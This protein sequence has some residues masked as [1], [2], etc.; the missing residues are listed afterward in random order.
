MSSPDPGRELTYAQALYE[1]THQEM[2]R[3]PDVFV[4]GMGVDDPKGIHGTTKDLHERFGP[5]RC[6]DT[7]LAEDGMTGIAIGAAMAGMRPVHVHE[8]VDFM[9]LCMNQ[10]I[11]FAAKARYMFAGRV[12]VPLTVRAAIGRSW[13]QGPQHSQALQSLFAHIPGL[14]VAVPATAHDAKGCLTAA[15]RSDD[16]VI[17][18]EH[19]MLYHLPGQVPEAPFETPFGRARILDEGCD[20]TIVGISHMA[21]EALR[22]RSLLADAGIDAAVIDPV[23][24]TPIDIDT[25][26]ASACKTGRL[27]VVDNGWLSC[28]VSAEIIAQVVERLGDGPSIRCARMGFA[29]TPCPT[30]RPLENLFYPSAAA[31]ARRAHELVTGKAPDWS[32]DVVEPKEV[33]A[34]KGPF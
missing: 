34:F 25:I 31:I 24:L 6:F 12:Q 26:A 11:N 30:T 22:A 32:E 5:E 16:P 27:L 2:E 13:G 7:P 15:I 20:V 23:T 14:K 33:A 8:R 19:R 9:L 4:L 21:L 29:A 18:L 1:A 10:L 17:V 3:D 28:G